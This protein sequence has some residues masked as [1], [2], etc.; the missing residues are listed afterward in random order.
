MRTERLLSRAC[1]KR[2]AQYL[3]Q[4]SFLEAE[5]VRLEWQEFAQNA[6]NVAGDDCERCLSE[7]ERIKDNLV[8]W[9]NLGMRDFFISRKPS[10][11]Y[12]RERWLEKVVIRYA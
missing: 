8:L 10:K 5:A 7:L 3:T 9:F 4:Q 12:T 1:G 2:Y 6:A 11:P